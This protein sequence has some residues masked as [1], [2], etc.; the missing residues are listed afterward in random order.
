MLDYLNWLETQDRRCLEN[1]LRYNEDDVR[2][3]RVVCDW[4]RGLPAFA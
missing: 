4:L 3:T 2:A 1:I